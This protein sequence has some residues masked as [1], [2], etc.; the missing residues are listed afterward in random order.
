MPQT[1][2]PIATTTL[3]IASTSITFSSIPATYSDLR[4]VFVG[5]TV[6]SD[7]ISVRVNGD[8]SSSYSDTSL[9][10]RG[11]AV[12]SQQLSNRTF[13]SLAGFWSANTDTTIFM[14]TLDIFSYTQG[15]NKTALG[16]SSLD[17]NGSGDVLR[18]I[19]L[20]RSASVINSLTVAASVNMPIGTTATLY[21]I[22]NA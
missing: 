3:G 13:W 4:L 10:G 20:W 7:G 17:K 22:K 21:G 5:S 2:D 15:V 19:H 18:T 8:T 11:T 9:E 1:Y 12:A 14:Q 16:T 6:S